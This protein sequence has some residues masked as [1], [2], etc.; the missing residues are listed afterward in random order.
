MSGPDGHDP[1]NR[2]RRRW[3]VWTLLAPA[4]LVIF[5]FLIFQAVFDSDLFSGSDGGD[6]GATEETI[7]E[8]LTESQL[9]AV[10][11]KVKPGETLSE[12]AAAFGYTIDELTACNPQ[13][14]PQT[15]Q[16]GDYVLVKR[17]VCSGADKAA[18][19]ADPDPLAG[20]TAIGADELAG[21]AP[22]QPAGDAA[23]DA[24]ADG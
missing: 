17:D 1:I 10:R 18:V 3:S 20:E 19:G 15:I 8:G 21:T 6:D 12:I 16:A 7:D 4:A 2:R 9:A 11:T 14:D 5:S 24:A 23:A 13:L 22:P